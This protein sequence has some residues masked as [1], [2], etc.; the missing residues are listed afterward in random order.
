LCLTLAWAAIGLED[1]FLA[2]EALSSVSRAYL[3]LHRVA[4]YL[5]CCTQIEEAA[6]PLRQARA[7]GH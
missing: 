1:P 5:S 7:A 6:D 4:A 3:D 2:H